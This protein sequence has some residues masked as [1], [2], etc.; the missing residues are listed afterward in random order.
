MNGD[1]DSDLLVA[2]CDAIYN[3][4]DCDN[5][6]VST[7][8]VLINVT[9]RHTK[10]PRSHRS[11][12][13]APSSSN[14]TDGVIAVKFALTQNNAPTCALPAA[15]IAITRT[16]GGTVGSVDEG[17]YSMAADRGSNFRIDQTA[18]Q[19]VYN[20][21]TALGVGTYEVDIKVNGVV[22]GDAVFALK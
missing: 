9:R 16:A 12:P 3:V 13:M 21:G 11:T 5:S 10:P 17:S 7:V 14:P 2:N 20:H 18:C 15:T 8:G 6:Q 22:V 1:K 19:Y 4:R